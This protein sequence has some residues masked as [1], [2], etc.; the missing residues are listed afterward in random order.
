M[1]PRWRSRAGGGRRAS[2]RGWLPGL[3]AAVLAAIALA[4]G[5][6]G[7]P[8]VP[9]DAAA[10]A[11][12]DLG[13]GADRAP[14]CLP[15]EPDP[16]AVDP[17]CPIVKPAR[18]DA[19]DEVLASV[20]LD[21]CSLLVS[22]QSYGARDSFRLPWYDAAHDHP[23]NGPAFARTLVDRLD[24]AAASATP[25]AAQ[26]V[27]LGNR[28]GARI[29]AC[30]PPRDLDPRAP[31]AVAVAQLIRG[32]DGVADEAA[33]A[34]AAMSIPLELQRA[35]AQVVLAVAAANADFRAL[36]AGLSPD[37]LAT[38]AQTSGMVLPYAGGGAPDVTAAA[39]RK[40]LAR[41]WNETSL[42]AGAARLA[43]AVEG[44]DLKRFAGARGFSFDVATPAGR[45]VIRDA[46]DHVY[47]DDGGDAIAVLIDTGGND[48]Y[49]APVG[50]V[51][52]SQAVAMIPI[53]VAVAVDLAGQDRYGYPESPGPL[54][55]ARDK[56]SAAVQRLPSDDDG[57]YRRSSPLDNGPI[58]LSDQVRQ[59]GAR[60]GYA[61]LLDLGP[62]AD[63]Y[64]SLR[65]SQGFG[66]AG[67]GVLYDA[68]GD[69]LYEG[70]AGVQG[71]GIFGVGLLLDAGGNDVYRT[72][73]D[74]QGFGYVR[75]AGLLY[76]A[77]GDDRYLADTG[78]PVL[79]GDPIFLSP[80]APCTRDNPTCGNSSFTQGVGFGRRP[81]GGADN[82]SMSGGLGVLRDR[83]GN[84]VYVTSVFGQAS[85]YWLGTGILADG[86]GADSYDGW[87]YT[88]GSA[89]HAALTVFVDDSGDDRYDL[90][91]PLN[92]P[93]AT[94]TGQGHDFSVGWHLDLGGNDRY[95]APG[96]G[97]GG[98][99]A[100]G[101]GLF[102]NVGG[103]DQYSSPGGTILGGAAFDLSAGRPPTTP[104]Y[105][106]FLDLGGKDTYSVPPDPH[107]QP[108]PADNTAW[109]NPRDPKGY[110]DISVGVD[111]EAGALSLP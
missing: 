23:V 62:E 39:T 85:G 49:R 99:N 64:R 66:C 26:L 87:W 41:T 83:R 86:G 101:A 9:L 70:E 54:D 45:V 29:E 25:I 105:G 53:R 48:V 107:L 1:N 51:G 5:C 80:Q 31:L 97:L 33:L 90:A 109:T 3:W 22:T 58:S 89:A 27:L 61:L 96:L 65:M 98:G 68:G 6:A 20:G 84:D 95:R 67:V 11:A 17:A 81:P 92:P 91:F 108:P 63:H 110:N 82:A 7:S 42:V 35:A 71:A 106:L 16:P 44:A 111:R 8:E 38:L 47:E 60:L 13:P 32:S 79:G 4:A 36:V 75:G 78:I 14:A 74:A 57:R 100:N 93:Y 88:Q 21:R 24:T 56:A 104:C 40:L 77:A 69:D 94:N 73:A 18:P 59:G 50:A 28:L 46:E 30:V 55:S 103:D 15:V 19:L 12:A 72:Y 52:G 10:P 2:G 34:A 76:D 43:A 102:V 37:D